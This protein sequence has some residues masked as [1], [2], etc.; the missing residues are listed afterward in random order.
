MTSDVYR[1]SESAGFSSDSFRA[2]QE[3]TKLLEAEKLADLAKVLTPAELAEYQRHN[4]D[5]ARTVA[6]GVASLDLTE[7]EFNAL[8]EARVA[9]DAVN[10]PAGSGVVTLDMQTQRQAATNAYYERAR[11]T[12]GDERF[13]AFLENSDGIY[14]TVRQSVAQFPSATPA[15]TYAVFGLRNELMAAMSAFRNTRPSPEQIQTLFSEFNARLDATLGV[16]AAKAFRST[17]F[18][19]QF[20]PPVMRPATP[21]PTPRT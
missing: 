20:T 7:A 16:E 4:S 14:R 5:T 18:G 1:S 10:P 17:S 3:Q 2:Q 9:H 11:A 21:A 15:A 13:Y 19:R 12:L 8:Y 6:R